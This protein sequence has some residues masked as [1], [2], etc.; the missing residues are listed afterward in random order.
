[1][2]ACTLTLLVLTL[3]SGAVGAP[4]RREVENSTVPDDLKPNNPAVPAGLAVDAVLQRIVVLRFKHRT[5]LLTGMQE[6]I[7][8]QRIRNAV[9]LAGIGSTRGYHIHVV[10]NRTFPTRNVFVKD[11]EAPAD[12][13]TMSGYVIGGRVH[14]H[15]TLADGERAFGGH[16]EPGTEVFTFAIVTLGILG[17]DVDLRRVDDKHD[18]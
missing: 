16:L 2:K 7:A 13:T 17:D 15:I 11:P 18:R 1:M 12:I 6:L 14:A 3:S 10:S 8:A 9:I 4:I 5:D